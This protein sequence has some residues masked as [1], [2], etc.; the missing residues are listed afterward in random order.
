MQ[1]TVTMATEDH[2]VWHIYS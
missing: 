2:A 1:I